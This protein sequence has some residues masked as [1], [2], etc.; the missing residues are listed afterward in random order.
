M[1]KS[2]LLLAMVSFA[3]LTAACSQ[4]T[5]Q[6]AKSEKQSEKREETA[7]DNNREIYKL[8]DDGDIEGVKKYIK[9]KNINLKDSDGNTP[10]LYALKNPREKQEIIKILAGGKADLEERDKDGYTPLMIACK[11]GHYPETALTLIGAGANVNAVYEKKYNDE[12]GMTPLMFAVS[13]YA[14]NDINVV[15]ALISAGANVNAKNAD[16]NTPLII[17]SRYMWLKPEIVEALI[18]A[19][20][21]LEDRDKYGYTPLMI[22]L[23]KNFSK[24]EL[25]IVLINAGANVNA[26]YDKPYDEKNGTTALMFAAQDLYVNDA[27]IF[28][29]MV[30]A[31]AEVNAKNDGGETVLLLAASNAGDPEVI[32]ILVKGGANIEE[33]DKNGRTPLMRAVLNDNKPFIAIK[34]LELKADVNAVN[35]S[36]GRT[37][38]FYAFTTFKQA[39]SKVVRALIDYGAKINA[40]DSEG[41]TPLIEAAKYAKDS[42]CV[43]LLLK[44]GAN[45]KAVDA[46]GRTAFDYA[47]NNYSLKNWDITKLK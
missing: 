20:A 6:A 33:K 18:K 23:R 47:P 34:F 28:Q 46:K 43:E 38:I 2:V 21:N 17:A 44:A 39:E 40:V 7:K 1:K 10:L 11:S 22:A 19:G 24:I 36:N 13:E 5:E 35:E 12:E 16:G 9:P 4:K 15:N 30:D 41:N 25:P 29:A 3:F 8:I 37:P 27:K 26:A 31:G 42:E 32:E 14:I 45:K